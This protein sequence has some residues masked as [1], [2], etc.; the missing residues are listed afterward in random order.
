MSK[1]ECFNCYKVGYIARECKLL[2]K[3]SWKPVTKLNYI[4]F[5]KGDIYIRI[6][7]NEEDNSYIDKCNMGDKDQE[8]VYLILRIVELA[9]E[10]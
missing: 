1:T 3:L 9:T 5:I 4:R 10:V 2:K 6:I 8:V 7:Y